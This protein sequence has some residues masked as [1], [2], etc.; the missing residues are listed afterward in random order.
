MLPFV[1]HLCCSSLLLSQP[2]SRKSKFI[3]IQKL[4]QGKLEVRTKTGK[5]AEEK[6]D[7]QKVPFLMLALDLPPARLFQDAMEANII[8]Q[9]RVRLHFLV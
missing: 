2:A 4:V 8:P 7:V 9:V 6:E 5:G 3:H 1:L